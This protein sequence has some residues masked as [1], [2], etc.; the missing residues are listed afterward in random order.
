M[1]CQKC[2]YEFG[3]LKPNFCPNCGKKVYYQPVKRSTMKNVDFLRFLDLEEFKK[4]W[5]KIGSLDAEGAFLWMQQDHPDVFVYVIKA[6]YERKTYNYYGEYLRTEEGSYDRST[7]SEMKDI[8]QNESKTFKYLRCN[9]APRKVLLTKQ[10]A[11]GKLG[12]SWWWTEAECKAAIDETLKTFGPL[13][14]A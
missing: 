3:D 14:E 5:E 11:I 13:K 1:K 8:L 2:A 10:F 9:F 12:E 4:D 6:K 7:I